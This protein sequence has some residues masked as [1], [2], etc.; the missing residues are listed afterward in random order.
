MVNNTS[1]ILHKQAPSSTM[2]KSTSDILH[3]QVPSS[4]M[5]KNTSDLFIININKYHLVPW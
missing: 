2:V 4:T 1:D 3:K 5:V